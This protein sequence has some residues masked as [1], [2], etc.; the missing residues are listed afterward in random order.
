MVDVR[1]VSWNTFLV[2]YLAE[3]RT[4]R[5][6]NMMSALLELRPLPDV[7]CLQ[8]LFFQKYVRMV[9]E[10]LS[11]SYHIC[12]GAKTKAYPPWFLPGANIGGLFYSIRK[13]GL[14]TLV[15]NCWNLECATL[16]YFSAEAPDW[17]FWQGDGYVDKGY[18]WTQL[19]NQDTGER[20]GIVN[21]HLQ[22]YDGYD[23]IREKQL[24]QIARRIAGPS[25]VM[26]VLIVG[27]FN[28]KEDSRVFRF[29]TERLRWKY[30]S[31]DSAYVCSNGVSLPLRATGT[32]DHVFGVGRAFHPTGVSSVSICNR[33][34]A[35][36]FSD[37]DGVVIDITL[38]NASETAARYA[39]LWKQTMTRRA[40]P[41][42][43]VTLWRALKAI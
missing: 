12:D 15:R 19:T 18:Q 7:I 17:K 31:Q 36:P 35:K 26:P 24:T 13:T 22:A 37:H 41:L 25:V 14:L 43:L 23:R 6:R 9:A 4:Q 28:A 40:L 34:K 2:P 27:D 8:E 32:V 30:L 20:F 38:P 33:R 42:H 11:V 10:V 5:L 21:T 29:M 3:E 16:K 39:R 1:V